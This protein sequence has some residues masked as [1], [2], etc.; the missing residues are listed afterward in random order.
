M[1]VGS[2][3]GPAT[4]APVRRS[5]DTAALPERRPLLLLLGGCHG[6]ER[7][8]A[9]RRRGPGVR[10][11]IAAKAYRAQAD[12]GAPV[13][14]V[15]RGGLHR[16]TGSALLAENSA[17]QAKYVHETCTCEWEAAR[18]C[19]SSSRDA[20]SA[21]DEVDASLGAYLDSAGL[22]AACTGRTTRLH[23]W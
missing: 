5:F 21:R 4:A 3:G 22:S 12:A 14:S 15:G 6:A 19:A 18:L 8:R 13:V 2:A 11:E 23:I 20:S 7:G 10:P 17:L 9:C 1:C 16:A